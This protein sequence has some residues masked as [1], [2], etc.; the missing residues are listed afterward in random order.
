MLRVETGAPG[1]SDVGDELGSGRFGDG[2]GSVEVAKLVVFEI[3]SLMTTDPTVLETSG[4]ALLA[5]KQTVRY[6]D[7]RK[8]VNCVC[9]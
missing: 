6:H 2:L 9:R 4:V 8:V 7:S 5:A 1:V 3:P